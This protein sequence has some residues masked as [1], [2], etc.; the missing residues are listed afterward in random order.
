MQRTGNRGC[1]TEDNRGCSAENSLHRICAM[2]KLNDDGHRSVE[3]QTKRFRVC[4]LEQR[5]AIAAAANNLQAN[6]RPN[7][8][9]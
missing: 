5:N 2:K 7:I 8:I 9:G 1:N 3:G 4:P 6:P